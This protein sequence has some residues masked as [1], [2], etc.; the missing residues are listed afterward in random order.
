MQYMLDT[1]TISDLM[2]ARP[3]VVERVKAT[4][5]AAMCMSVITEAELFY[6]L[7]KRPD[8]KRLHLAAQELMRRIDVLPWNSATAHRYAGVRVD[9]ERQGKT[10]APLDLLIA[11]HAL[12]AGLTLV[13]RDKVFGQVDGLVVQDWSL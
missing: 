5:M 7:A 4:P 6:G 1:N 2:K 9:L 3:E 11:A 13:S 12:E 8:A 10:L